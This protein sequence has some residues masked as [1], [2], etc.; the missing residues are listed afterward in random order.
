MS[1]PRADS[2][3]ARL[4][5]RARQQ[6]EDFNLLLTRYALE[7]W[8]YRFSTSEAFRLAGRTST[9]IGGYNHARG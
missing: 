4:L 7:R 5:Q 6:G 2:V 3:R 1:D 9:E 8:L